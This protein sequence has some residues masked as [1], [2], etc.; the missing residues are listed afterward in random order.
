MV[1]AVEERLASISPTRRVDRSVYSDPNIPEYPGAVFLN[2]LGWRTAH[3]GALVGCAVVA[4]LSWMRGGRQVALP[5]VMRRVGGSLLAFGYV[6]GVGAGYAAAIADK[7]LDPKRGWTD[8]AVN[9]YASRVMK[10][11]TFQRINDFTSAG[12]VTCL[13]TSAGGGTLGSLALGAS[14]GTAT[15]AFIH[16]GLPAFRDSYWPAIKPK[17]QD[18]PPMPAGPPLLVTVTAASFPLVFFLLTRG[19]WKQLGGS[20]AEE[21]EKDDAARSSY[22][23]SVIRHSV[24]TYAPTM[25]TRHHIHR[26]TLH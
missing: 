8:A 21:D 18:L 5:S 12:M 17:L 14:A 4:P 6:G 26:C 19:G 2:H 25:S 1:E 3:M 22:R 11:E 7:P 13:T 23:L 16:L 20:M 15:Y 9:D 24:A 10:D